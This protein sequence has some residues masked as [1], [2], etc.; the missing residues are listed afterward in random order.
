MQIK[1]LACQNHDVMCQA[2]DVEADI[3]IYRQYQYLY[4]DKY[5]CSCPYT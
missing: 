1:F 2:I 5:L 4:T 3:D